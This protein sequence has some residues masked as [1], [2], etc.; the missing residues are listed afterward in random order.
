[1][2]VFGYR[3]YKK[4]IRD[5]VD[6][7][8]ENLGQR[9]SYQKL[10]DACGIQKTYLSRVL[11]DEKAQLSADQLYL[12]CQFLSVG[13]EESSFLFQIY[14]YERSQD[15]NRKKELLA[16]IEKKHQSKMKTENVIEAKS[17]EA[18]AEDYHEFFLDPFQQLVHG[19]LSIEKYQKNPD[20]IGRKLG[21]TQAR[22]STILKKMVRLGL[23]EE[24]KGSYRLIKDSLHLPA[25]SG[26][27]LPYQ[28]LLRLK[29]L[30]L[31]Q[32]KVQDGSYSFSVIFS[33]DPATRKA[34]QEG[35][36]DFLKKVEKFVKNAPAEEV[37]QLN[38]DLLDWSE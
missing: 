24:K 27:Y 37:Y 11:H 35:F 3:S 8:K 6:K 26:Y 18:R 28:S 38:F 16:E 33:A 20:A 15:K 14:E 9:V 21:L 17:V 1:M 2:D 23:I 29:A 22:L 25:D 34:I 32:R 4:F 31:F 19:F 30:D 5:K 10:A 7:M 12:A 13:K 36:F